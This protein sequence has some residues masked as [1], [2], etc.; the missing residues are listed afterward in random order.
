MTYDI[1]INIS[2]YHISKSYHIVLYS[3]SMSKYGPVRLKSITVDNSLQHSAENLQRPSLG[4]KKPK[5][6]RYIQYMQTHTHTHTHAHI[7]A[8]QKKHWTKLRPNSTAHWRPSDLLDIEA[9]VLKPYWRSQNA[10]YSDDMVRYG[11]KNSW[12]K[13]ATRSLKCW[14]VEM[15]K[16]LNKLLFNH[17][18]VSQAWKVKASGLGSGVGNFNRLP[19]ASTIS[20]PWIKRIFIESSPIQCWSWHTHCLSCTAYGWPVQHL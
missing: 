20:V 1:W 14:N 4:C 6:H 17:Q 7:L 2:S 12:S 18:K 15:L 16:C 3:I 11:C 9:L 8:H 19:E 13:T 10:I 5:S